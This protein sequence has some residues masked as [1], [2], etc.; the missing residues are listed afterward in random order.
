MSELLIDPLLRLQDQTGDRRIDEIFIRL[1]RFL[2]DVGSSYY[3]NE[4]LDDHFL[5]PKVCDRQNDENRRRLVPL[6]GAGLDANGHRLRE[7]Q[8]ADARHCADATALTAAALRALR[9]SGGFDQHPVGPFASEG[10]SFVQMHQEFAACAQRTFI[11]MTRQNRDPGRFVLDD[12]AAAL[13]DPLKYVRDHKL[14]WPSHNV[15]P[16]RMLS[17]W[18]NTSLEQFSLLREAGVKIDRLNPGK[19]GPPCQ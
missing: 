1:A 2:R 15:S 10:A 18:F 16:Q 13:A 17:W 4:V 11:E 3:T 9:R 12:V 7:A 14:G 6:Y 8:D 5:Q 19:L